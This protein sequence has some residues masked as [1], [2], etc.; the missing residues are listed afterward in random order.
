MLC[1]QS[2]QQQYSN[3]TVVPALNDPAPNKTVDRIV[4]K[5]VGPAATR[6]KSPDLLVADRGSHASDSLIRAIDE[7]DPKTFQPGFRR[8]D[9]H[10]ASEARRQNPKGPSLVPRP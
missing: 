4:D 1:F 3:R 8:G 7:A 2:T 5:A 6:K 9:T 10:R